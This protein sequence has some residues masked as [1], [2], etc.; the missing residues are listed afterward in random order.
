[1]CFILESFFSPQIK[2]NI[3]Q[4]YLIGLILSF[5]PSF[6]ANHLFAQTHEYEHSH[7]EETSDV[8]KAQTQSAQKLSRLF[9]L[10]QEILKI[11]QQQQQTQSK[12]DEFQTLKSRYLS[13]IKD[14]SQKIKGNRLTLLKLLSIREQV[15]S[16][17]IVE[18]LLNADGPLDQKRREVY[19]QAVFNSGSQ[20]FKALLN[21]RHD[22]AQRQR[23]IET[24]DQKEIQ[25]KQLLDQQAD[26]LALKRR[27][28]WL[29]IDQSKQVSKDYELEQASEKW[30]S[31][32]RF[33]PAQ[34]QWI[35]EFRKFRGLSLAKMFGGGI[36][37]QAQKGAP[38]Y[39]VESGTVLFAGTIKGWGQVLIIEHKYNY[40]TVYANLSELQ[41]IEGQTVNMQQ[42]VSVI[43]DGA[44]REGLYFELR[45]GGET[46]HPERWLSHKLIA[47]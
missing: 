13:E 24:L 5:L 6:A 10:D 32:K 38:V 26:E 44:G 43:D 36:W 40:M 21:A 16:T 18:L 3:Y 34:G 28:E 7:M 11:T 4:E 22:L 17:R 25:L 41:V 8:N 45:R 30:V 23:A 14:L 19:I 27:Q 29:E 42:R 47:K 33:P 9:T 31:K 2:K 46:I 12:L 1:M 15:K 20:R 35:D 39:A 37:I